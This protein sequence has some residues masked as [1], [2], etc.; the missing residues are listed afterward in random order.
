MCF[1]CQKNNIFDTL[2]DWIDFHDISRKWISRIGLISYNKVHFIDSHFDDLIV[3]RRIIEI[4]S[5]QKENK[6]GA[7]KIVIEYRKHQHNCDDNSKNQVPY[8]A[9]LEFF[10]VIDEDAHQIE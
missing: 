5:Q 9:F 4:S 1:G 2:S 10:S 8:F 3:Y 6:N 7:N